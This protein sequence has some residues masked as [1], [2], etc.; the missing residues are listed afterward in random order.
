MLIVY[1]AIKYPSQIKGYNYLIYYSKMNVPNIDQ[2]TSNR[3][4]S[5]SIYIQNK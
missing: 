3:Y 5:G 2:Y 4:F 1:P